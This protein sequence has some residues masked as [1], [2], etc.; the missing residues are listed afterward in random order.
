MH[1]LRHPVA[2][3]LTYVIVVVVALES[4][5]RHAS[6]NGALPAGDYPE[7]FSWPSTPE[8]IGLP[9]SVGVEAERS[10]LPPIDVSANHFL[11]EQ[12]RNSL[13]GDNYNS[14]TLNYP[15]PLGRSPEVSSRQL[16]LLAA[17]CPTVV[18]D[19]HSNLMTICIGVAR[20]RLFLMDPHSLE[21]LAEQELPLRAW[22]EAGRPEDITTD[23]S[24]GGYFH[25]DQFGRALV[26]VANQRIQRWEAIEVKNKKW[27]WQLVDDYDLRPV[28]NNPDAPLQDALPD[29]A[30]HLWFTTQP[31]IIG[32][33]DE[34]TAEVETFQL[35]EFLQNGFA[36]DTDG[37]IYAVTVEAL[38]RLGVQGDGSIAVEW[39]EPYL[40]DGGQGG[41]LSQGSGTT[42]TLLG[43]DN[44]L[45]AIADNSA[46]RIN[47]NVYLRETGQQVCEFPMF[48]EGASATENSPIGYGND[49]VLENNAGYPGPFGD[50]LLTTPGL[51]RVRVRD[52]LSGCEL[53]WH[54]TEFRAQTT[55][56]LSTDNGLIYTYSVKEGRPFKGLI[57]TYGWYFGALDWKTGE[58]VYEAWVGN[59]PNWNNVLDPIT[60]GPDGTAYVGTKNGLM[61]IRDGK[62]SNK[63]K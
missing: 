32:Y 54:T 19:A 62:K 11:A 42:P 52:D 59:G 18:F 57:P 43:D 63:Q 24:G 15:A 37:A 25:A 34:N 4:A 5:A 31:G 3:T 29:Y 44:D 22:V 13:H 35:G 48:D 50:P 40:N 56:R 58:R 33:I 1:N 17:T 49:I 7:L 21:V 36:I 6:A 46:G 47:L 41:L 45:V 16:G 51:T 20:V 2:L 60:L 10:P 30:G 55:P 9:R 26:G 28:L 14:D 39:R 23:S 38:Y 8:E 27:E 53:V 61:A 12:G